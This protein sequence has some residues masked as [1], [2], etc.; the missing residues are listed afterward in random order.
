MVT[1]Q[2]ET[3]T[4]TTDCPGVHGEAAAE[5]RAQ[6]DAISLGCENG[7]VV[8]R[9][10][11]FHKVAVEEDYQR[12]GNQADFE[13]SPIVL[14]DYKT[15][16][17]AEQECPTRIGLIDTCADT[18]STVV[19]RATAQRHLARMAQQYAVVVVTL[20]YGSAGRPEHLYS[21]RE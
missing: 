15:D 7:P 1:P 17:D 5:L 16:P 6:D 19:S 21:A 11:A 10:G 14:T 18:D 12:S 13:T 2:G 4:E 9:D 3:V 8:Y 20:R